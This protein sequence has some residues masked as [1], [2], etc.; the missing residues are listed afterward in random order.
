MLPEPS[1]LTSKTEPLDELVELI[2]TAPSDVD[3]ASA[4]ES[5]RITINNVAI[6]TLTKRLC[7]TC[8]KRLA[9]VLNLC[10]LDVSIFLLL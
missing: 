5:E 9:R 8:F 4:G 1:T 7:L 2:S 3:H 6:S 10:L